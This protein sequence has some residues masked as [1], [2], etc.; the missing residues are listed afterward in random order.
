MILPTL[1]LSADLTQQCLHLQPGLLNLPPLLFKPRLLVSQSRL[2]AAVG[3]QLQT[4]VQH[5]QAHAGAHL[6]SRLGQPFT[7]RRDL[8]VSQGNGKWASSLQS[9]LGNIRDDLEIADFDNKTIA[10]V[11]EQQYSMFD[12]FGVPYNKI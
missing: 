2:L 6:K 4:A 8:R 1:F 5:L 9:E 3:D 11:L 12:K 10:E 7:L